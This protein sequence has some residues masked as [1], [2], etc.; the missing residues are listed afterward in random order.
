MSVGGREVVGFVPVATS[1]GL[2]VFCESDALVG[3]GAAATAGILDDC[4]SDALVGVGSAATVG[5]L[6]VCSSDPLV[7]VGATMVVG[8][9][10]GRIAADDTGVGDT[11]NELAMTA[12][13]SGVATLGDANGR[14]GTSSDGWIFI[15]G[16]GVGANTGL[17]G[18][19]TG[20]IVGGRPNILSSTIMRGAAEG[21]S[22][23]VTLSAIISGGPSIFPSA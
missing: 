19:V 20:L 22:V 11:V 15:V 23:A 2:L 8:P 10:V 1:D 12:V 17:V 4:D 6:V 5:P 16:D 18:V 14:L 13:G 21:A 9:E 7:G 3:V